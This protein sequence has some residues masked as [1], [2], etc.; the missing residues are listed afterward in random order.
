MVFCMHHPER[1]GNP[2]KPFET[3]RV[4]GFPNDDH[5]VGAKGRAGL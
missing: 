3:K 5:A 2:L 1:V 4:E